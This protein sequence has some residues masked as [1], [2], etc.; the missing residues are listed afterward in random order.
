MVY[1]LTTKSSYSELG[2]AYLALLLIFAIK[3]GFAV[4]LVSLRF[5]Q[6]FLA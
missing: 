2:L 1:G 4:G 3:S 6:L 5:A